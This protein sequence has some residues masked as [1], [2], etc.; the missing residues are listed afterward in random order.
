MELEREENLA[1]VADNL[2]NFIEKF[3]GTDNFNVPTNDEERF[4]CKL[5]H[6]IEYVYPCLASIS[7]PAIFANDSDAIQSAKDNAEDAI[8][9]IVSKYTPNG[10]L[11][12]I[13]EN[14]L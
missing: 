3:D 14:N 11:V 9:I 10:E 12:K 13:F 7:S 5:T 4:N 2:W 8:T 6:R 1:K